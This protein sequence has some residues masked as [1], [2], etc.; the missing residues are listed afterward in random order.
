MPRLT[1]RRLTGILAALAA[2]VAVSGQ[3]YASILFDDAQDQYLQVDNNLGITAY[4]FTLAAWIKSNDAASIQVVM[5]LADKDASDEYAT[6]EL[7]GDMAGD[8]V[9][10]AVRDGAG[11]SAN[12]SSGY[13]ANT[14]HSVVGV[15]ASA[16]DR[17]I[18][19]DGGA[20]GTDTANFA[21]P[22]SFDRFFVGHR[23]DLTP[24]NPFSG[25]IAHVVVDAD[26]AWTDEQAGSFHEA[27]DP[28]SVG[29]PTHY[30]ELADAS[31][32]TD[33]IGAVTLTAFNSPD[34]GND[35]PLEPAVPN[36]D[37]NVSI[38]SKRV[39]RHVFEEN[40]FLVFTSHNVPYATIPPLAPSESYEFNLYETDGTT[41]VSVTVSHRQV[42]FDL[43]PT[44]YYPLNESA[45]TIAEDI[46]GND[47][48]GTYSGAF[49]FGQA[50]LD[51]DGDGAVLLEDDAGGDGAVTVA[52]HYDGQLGGSFSVVTLASLT[53][54]NQTRLVR[55][56]GNFGIW[57]L[58]WP[59][60]GTTTTSRFLLTHGVSGAQLSA[61][62][63][64]LPK[65]ATLLLAG[66]Y[67]STTGAI[68]HYVYNAET[69]AFLGSGASSLSLAGWAP[70]TTADVL[71]GESL[72]ND[73][74]LDEVSIFDGRVL[75]SGQVATLAAR[76]AAVGELEN[77]A[78]LQQYNLGIT[79]VYRSL[80]SGLTWEDPYVVEVRG[81]TG[82]V[83][84]TPNSIIASAT[85]T[86]DDYETTSSVAETAVALKAYIF[87]RMTA[88]EG[89]YEIDLLNGSEDEYVL[90][91]PGAAFLRASFPESETLFPEIFA[92]T[93][94]PVGG[95][96]PTPSSSTYIQDTATQLDNSDILSTINSPAGLTLTQV[97]GIAAGVAFFAIFL[98]IIAKTSN[99]PLAFM[100]STVFAVGG[101]AAVGFVPLEVLFA[102]FAL[103]VLGAVATVALKRA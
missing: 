74:V 46:S 20:K 100:V 3:A 52:S 58:E 25:R 33:S 67:D 95:V 77:G 26:T 56:A 8:P 66:T 101:G 4:P 93:L 61:A 69:G 76:V 16:T 42:A 19:I 38:V 30:W 15:F 18:Y 41:P 84:L 28:T 54:L 53:G 75:T 62:V 44:G 99:V 6:V 35:D 70:D 64:G 32:L 87:T 10:L 12:T 34:D 14:W 72:L 90:T 79:T 9:Q 86:E 63:T 13:S 81:K 60:A 51:V 49:T 98:I 5:G 94:F 37:D 103:L 40:D 57:R 23:G 73:V 11:V 29:S 91:A 24:T 17:R 55:R 50:A 1:V 89:F 102:I 80:G 47:F 96:T 39:F 7:R 83:D 31:D 68:T 97:K 21:L 65:P 27:A 92:A 43:T 71:F 22:A 45:G 59:M 78:D 82:V 85:L 2:V 88:A 36:P 48:D